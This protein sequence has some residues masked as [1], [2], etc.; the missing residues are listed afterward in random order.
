MSAIAHTFHQLRQQQRAALMPYFTLGY[1]DQATSLKIIE[2]IAPYSDLL[3]LGI[4]FS[5]PLADG[6]TIQHSTQIALE[7][8]T[9]S[10]TCLQ[11]VKKLRQR[12]VALPL[13]LMGY[14]N[15]ILAYGEKQFVQDAAQAGAN[16][17]IVPDLPPEEADNLRQAAQEVDLHLISFLAPTSSSDRI[18]LVVTHASGFIYIVSTTGVTGTRTHFSQSLQSL[19]AQVRA[20]TDIPLAVGFGVSR[21]DQ[22]AQIGQ[23]ADGVIVG[24]ALI[25]VVNHSPN[26]VQAAA[27]FVQSLQQALVRKPHA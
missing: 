12:G 10:H 24:S 13:L 1:P 6:P 18:R 23:F 7:N 26:Q 16:G 9:T 21:P 15:P 8:K 2:A 25:N 27:D 3:E 17:L 5:D 11:M 4:P 14:Y 19:I 22:V 20:Q